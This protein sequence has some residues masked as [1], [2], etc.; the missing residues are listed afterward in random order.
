MVA[1]LGCDIGG[2]VRSGV[3]HGQDDPLDRQRWIEV[4]PNEIQSRGQLRKAFESV[5][6]ALRRDQDRIRRGE[7]IH[8]QQTER[9]GA[10]EKDVVKSVENGCQHLGHTPL[11][12]IGARELDLRA[13]ERNGGGSDRAALDGRRENGRRQGRVADDHVV[14][15]GLEG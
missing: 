8:G 5:V 1:N 6:L 4:V 12:L 10:I 11:A 15:G 7:R 13:R 2:Q 3:V 14:Q 9:W